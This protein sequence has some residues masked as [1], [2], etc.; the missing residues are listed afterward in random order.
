MGKASRRKK[1]S[2]K[3]T[4][5]GIA[6]LE[7]KQIR[8]ASKST[9]LNLI[10]IAALVA[11]VTFIVYLPA[12]QNDFVNWD[13]R[14]Y[15][16]EN[17]HIRSFDLHMLK[18]SFT[19]TE[20]MWVPLTK[21][22]H[23]LVYALWGLNPMGHHL[24]NIILHAINTFLLILLIAKLIEV[25]VSRSKIQDSGQG[26]E[27]PQI[28]PLSGE[29]KAGISR[30]SRFTLIAAATTGLLFGLHPIHVESVA[31]V[32]E[33]KDVLYSFFSL[34][35]FLSYLKYA[36]VL[37]RKRRSFY[38]GICLILF[39]FALLSKAMA[40]TLPA[41]LLIIDVYPLGRLKLGVRLRSQFKILIEKIPFFCL[42]LIYTI[43]I[44][45]SYSEHGKL[46]SVEKYSFMQRI[47][48][49]FYELFFYLYKMFLPLKL[50]PLYP[51][52]T[53]IS[54]LNLKYVGSFIGVVAITALCVYLWRRNKKVYLVAWAYYI[55]TLLPILGNIQV[56]KTEGADRYTYLSSIGL[57]LIVGLIAATIYKKIANLKQWRLILK[58]ASSVVAIAVLISISYITIQQIGIWK[59]GCALWNYVIEMEPEK[60]AN[61]YNNLG[62][63][64]YSKGLADKAI[65][66]YQAA[67]KIRPDFIEMYNNIGNIYYSKGL[68]DKA[69]EEY[70][71]AL[72]LKPD[73]IMVHNN[74]GLAYQSKGLFDK[75]IEEYQTALRLKPD[76]AK[77]H[78]NLG[79]IYLKNG[80][81]DMARREFEM[82]LEID[83]YDYKA[84]KILNSILSGRY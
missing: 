15:I 26:H 7:D 14:V 33:R 75:A 37:S 12:L 27:N 5:P 16:Y 49:S 35:C 60:N 41:I 83:P 80:T 52:P 22:S 20:L 73:Y 40:V 29:N 57:F 28:P 32:T 68:I 17:P 76:F 48:E 9:P 79:L 81:I 77:P 61:A 3:T 56:G 24:V 36:S 43:I 42:S 23:A 8:I 30:T 55:F 53:D 38:Y 82:G 65:E 4:E 51:Y 21:I 11:I 64:Y 58:M 25:W 66:Q 50:V 19:D 54:F 84:Q 63:A 44:V 13:D 69:I 1:K 2:S 78:F 67:L 18:Y 74:L 59:D 10:I 46:R 47:Y 71:T 70:Q 34:L 45:A 6:E 39:S 72:R 31:W 62:N